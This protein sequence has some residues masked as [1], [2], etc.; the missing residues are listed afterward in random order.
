MAV[1]TIEELR[2]PHPDQIRID[3]EAA[4]TLRRTAAALIRTDDG[5]L[6]PRRG[7]APALQGMAEKVD[8]EIR[9]SSA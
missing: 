2:R 3:L 1:T 8:V 6:H 7:L 5:F 9:G 4:R